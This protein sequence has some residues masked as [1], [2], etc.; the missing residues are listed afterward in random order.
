MGFSYRLV[1]MNEMMLEKV[2][3][4]QDVHVWGIASLETI[5]GCDGYK[6]IVFCLPYDETAIAS[7]PDDKLIECCKR[8]L[9]AKAKSIYTAIREEYSKCAFE[10]CDDVDRK[11]GLRKNGLSQKVLGHLA[12]LGWIGKSSLLVSPVLGPRIRLGTIFSRD[13]LGAIGVPSVG[14]CGECAICSEICPSG[15]ITESGYDVVKCRKIVTDDQGNYKTFCG[16]CMKVCPQG[17]ANNVMHTDVDS[18]KLHPRR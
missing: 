4:Q 11:L 14:D 5:Q 18:A 16:L 9:S 15:A 12:G 13:D 7:L 1:S 8:E 17:N 6:C 10:S 2:F 3:R